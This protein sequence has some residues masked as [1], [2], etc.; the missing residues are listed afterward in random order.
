MPRPSVALQT[1]YTKAIPLKDGR[2]A[3]ETVQQWVFHPDGGKDG[4]LICVEDGNHCIEL[5][6]L[7]EQL[8]LPAN[9]PLGIR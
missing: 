5:L 2:F 6:K 1:K 8:N 4:S 9:D 7:K 3:Y